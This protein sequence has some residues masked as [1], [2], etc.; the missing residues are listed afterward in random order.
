MKFQQLTG[1]AMA[2]GLEDT[3]FYRFNRLISLNEVGSDPAKFGVTVAEFHEA[4]AAIARQWPHTLLASA[5]HD[6]KRGEDARARLNVLSE[7]LFEWRDS[8][9]RWSRWNREKKTSLGDSTAPDAN[10]EYLL[11]QTLVG[12]WPLDED[13]GEGL[14]LFRQRIAAFML[15]AVKEAKVHTNWTEPDA[16]YEKALQD[17]VD[18]VLAEAGRNI[19]LEEIRCFSRRVAFFGR[20][21]SLSQT[22][23]KIGSPGVP[24]FYQGCELWDL[25]LVDP[26]NRRPV[27]YAVRQKLLADLKKKFGGDAAD[28]GELFSGLLR[29]EEP[30]AMKLFVIW[31]ALNFR[32]RQTEL[33]DR[34][35]Y[36]PVTASGRKHEHVCAFAR[37]WN[38]REI[39]VVVPRLVFG[40]T[41][42]T[43]TPPMGAEVWE[44]TALSLPPSR[45]GS[46]FRN[47]LTRET[48]A[49]TGQH[50]SA[51]LEVGEVLKSFPVALLEK[52]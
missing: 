34:G 43:E 21:N 23:L 6:T 25:N 35:D 4:N 13:A 39:I 8:V 32:G 9:T 38:D 15:K 36:L 26:D 18:R 41:R 28:G 1:P 51:A 44:D 30:G 16:A 50:A 3:A 47:V 7:M 33:F 17:F 37:R 40:L 49:V 12:A 52:I 2:K 48:V 24:D 42:G 45:A 27:A 46:L 10:D 20:F 22:L 11:Y 29:D 19:F 5:T 14:K 31:R